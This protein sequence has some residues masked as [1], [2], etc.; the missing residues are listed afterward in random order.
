MNMVST[1]LKTL[2]LCIC[3]FSLFANLVY[4][5]GK[6]PINES[7][8]ASE[9][10]QTDET[11]FPEA[12]VE[13]AV[14]I[15]DIPELSLEIEAFEQLMGGK[16]IKQEITEERTLNSKLFELEDGS[17]SSVQTL[18]NMHYVDENGG[19]EEI[20]PQIVESTTVSAMNRT[21]IPSLLPDSYEV[22]QIP[23]ELT[24]PK[25]FD[26]GYLIGKDHDLLQFIP[27][28]ASSSKAIINSET[29]KSAYYEDVWPSTDAELEVKSWGIKES[30]IL[31]NAD[32][33]TSFSFE[34]IG[35]INEELEGSKV[36]LLPAWLKDV[37]G[38]TR[39]V[40]QLLRVEGDKQYIDLIANTEGLQY[41]IVI[42]PTGVVR[43]LIEVYSEDYIWDI[44]L[45]EGAS[46]EKIQLTV[47]STSDPMEGYKFSSNKYNYEF[48][49][50][51]L[52]TR[53]RETH[54]LPIDFISPGSNRIYVSVLEGSAN[55]VL[56]ISYTGTDNHVTLAS[57]N[58]GEIVS[59]IYPIVIN[60]PESVGD[61][62]WEAQI[63]LDNGSTWKWLNYYFLW[64]SAIRRN[65]TMT[66][67]ADFGEFGNKDK[68]L[69]RVRTTSQKY[70]SSWSVPKSFTIGKRPT[71][72]T[73]YF[74]DAA[75]RIDYILFPSGYKIKYHYDANGNLI[76]RVTIY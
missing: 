25:D 8:G 16:S 29:L 43:E 45:L 39:Q 12:P 49:D 30:L 50:S 44:E 15:I 58:D 47:I 70:A 54:E 22:A 3:L 31:K 26:A 61:K 28:N 10:E 24:I 59:G 11:E 4:A 73:K 74:Y 32:A 6:N 13:D 34:V 76:K 14:E 42:D 5:V 37:E 38:R 64:S 56:E 57:P 9:I 19:L 52:Y 33:P 53:E 18:Q 62:E 60:I 2:L 65:G 35:E 7:N 1:R 46:I 40:N 66:V 41:P 20:R 67:F 48:L 27:L 63:S 68:A 17:L 71:F 55:F 23:F 72:E 51:Y 21:A 75:G 69:I 36:D